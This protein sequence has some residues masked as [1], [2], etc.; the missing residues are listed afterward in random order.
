MTL[1]VAI[2]I[3]YY[4]R[5]SGVLR[6][7]VESAFAQ[8]GVD[9]ARVMVVDDGSPVP[10]ERE[11]EG[12]RCP[13]GWSMDIVVQPN[14]G[15]GAA[16]NRGLDDARPSRYIAFLDSD[17][18]W[19]SD[20]L[21]RALFALQQ[22]YDVFFANHYQLDQTT[23]AFER[24]ERLR[25]ENHVVLGAE[26]GLYGFQGD[27]FYQ[28]LRGN[29]IGTSTM[30]FDTSRVGTCRF[31]T[32]YRRAGEDYLFWMSLAREDA[33]FCFSMQPQV[34]YGHG[35]NVYSGSAWGTAEHLRRSYDEAHYR[36][37]TGR[38]FDLTAAQRRHVS[39]KRAELREEFALALLHRVRRGDR[40][41]WGLV[42]AQTAQEPL[43]MWAVVKAIARRLLP[44]AVR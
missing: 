39:K 34:V 40:V 15:P 26:A 24:S 20:H 3:P 19:Q 29:V 33:K 17:D 32:E 22:G 25:L 23:P 16:R 37:A 30:I 44:S 8:Q 4:Q 5:E 43:T 27:M 6:R 18:C 7:A 31:R 42:R 28:V 9:G 11:L 36:R 2:V 21:R 12:L 1:P 14:G 35:I 13:Q 10:A 41:P 38:L